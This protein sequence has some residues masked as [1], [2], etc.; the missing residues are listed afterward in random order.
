[1]VGMGL[2][3]KA[4]PSGDAPTLKSK[5][6]GNFSPVEVHPGQRNVRTKDLGRRGKR[7]REGYQVLGRA[8]E[9]GAGMVPCIALEEGV[10]G[11][12]IVW[13]LNPKAHTC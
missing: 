8:N 2:V 11:L 13:G 4:H 7:G 3:G 5:M 10:I 6:D 9:R 12:Y 1:M